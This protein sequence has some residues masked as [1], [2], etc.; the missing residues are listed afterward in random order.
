MKRILIEGYCEKNRV[1]KKDNKPCR[2]YKGEFGPHCVECDW[3]SWTP[4][5][6]AFVYTNKNSTVDSDDVIQFGD[7]MEADDFN[8]EKYIRL[9]HKICSKKIDE[10][11]EEFMKYR[12][13]GI[14]E[15]Q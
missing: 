15:I 13:A 1:S 4:A 8:S 12:N 2:E 3:F 7:E 11:Y 9:W 14:D 6:N 10:A 5:E